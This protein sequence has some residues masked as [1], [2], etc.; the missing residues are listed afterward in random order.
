MD[1]ERALMVV[2]M[3]WLFQDKEKRIAVNVVMNDIY[4]AESD[5]DAAYLLSK[6]GI[7]GNRLV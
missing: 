3:P 7:W 4:A 2:R 6:S 1:R 5:H